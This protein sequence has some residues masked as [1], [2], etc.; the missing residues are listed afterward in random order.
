MFIM[1]SLLINSL[2][3]DKEKRRRRNKIRVAGTGGAVDLQPLLNS[4]SSVLTPEALAVL[5][6]VHKRQ[7]ERK[8]VAES[9]GAAP[10]TSCK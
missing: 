5:Q 10:R 2:L 6:R 8:Q 7:Q 3:Q 1:Y 4:N 9:G